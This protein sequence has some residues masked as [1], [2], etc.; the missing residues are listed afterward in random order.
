[1]SQSVSQGQG[2]RRLSSGQLKRHSM[3]ICYPVM[4]LKG[5]FA[6]YFQSIARTRMFFGRFTSLDCWSVNRSTGHLSSHVETFILRL[7]FAGFHNFDV[8]FSLFWVHHIIKVFKCCS[9]TSLLSFPVDFI[10]ECSHLAVLGP[11]YS[12]GFQ[13]V[14]FF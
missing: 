8:P 3:V 6:Y 7:T 13:M 11:S 1:M 10:P 14:K 5:H 9:F 4:R 2:Y 12:Q